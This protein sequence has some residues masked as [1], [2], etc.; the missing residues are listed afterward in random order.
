MNVHGCPY[1]SGHVQCPLGLP[2]GS[3]VI[4]WRQCGAYMEFVH[5]YIYIYKS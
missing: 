4:V 3:Y 2:P 5:I 1:T